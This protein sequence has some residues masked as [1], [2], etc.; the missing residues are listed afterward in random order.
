MLNPFPVYV[1][2]LAARGQG[3]DGVAA[4][5]TVYMYAFRSGFIVP[6]GYW[7]L[8]APFLAIWLESP[9]VALL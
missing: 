9:F 4:P 5:G 8:L 2:G 1:S 7:R 3:L 6:G